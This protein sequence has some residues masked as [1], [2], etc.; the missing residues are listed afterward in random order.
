MNSPRAIPVAELRQL[1]GDSIRLSRLRYAWRSC[2]MEVGGS[3]KHTCQS[4]HLVAKVVNQIWNTRRQY[5]LTT[6][7]DHTFIPLG[8]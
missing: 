4:Q 5:T 7:V 3:N 6:L 1:T 2:G 8:V